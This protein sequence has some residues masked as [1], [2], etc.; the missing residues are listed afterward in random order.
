MAFNV[1]DQKKTYFN[2]LK[3]EHN[4]DKTNTFLG[5][6]FKFFCESVDFI[7]CIQVCLN[8]YVCVGEWT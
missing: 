5:F 7:V 6:F 1:G 3:R 4:S 8:V 2:F